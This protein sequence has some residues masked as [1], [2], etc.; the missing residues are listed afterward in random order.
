V[1]VF[2][3]L[4][5]HLDRKTTIFGSNSKAVLTHSKTIS[6]ETSILSTKL[7]DFLKSSSQHTLK[8]RTEAT[9]FQA[10][11]LDTL[12][13]HSERINAQLQRVQEVLEV[14]QGKETVSTEALGVVCTVMKET[15]ESIKNGFG[16]WADGLKKT[17][18]AMC[19]EVEASEA[20]GFITVEKAL[21][22]MGCLIETIVREA[23]EVINV[24][25]ASVLQAKSLANTAANS[26]MV[27]LRQQ[28]EMLTRLLEC[29]RIKADRTKDELIQRITGLLGDYTRDRDKGLREAVGSIQQSNEEAEE[30]MRVFD[31]KYEGVVDEMTQ[32]AVM[33][34]GV[35]ERRSGE[36]KR[37]RDGAIKTMSVARQ[38]FGEELTKMQ[39]TVSGSIQTHSNQVQ[40]QTQAMNVTCVDGEWT[41][42][43]KSIGTDSG[44]PTAFDRH[45]GAKRARV[46]ATN[47]LMSDV[48]SEY[49]YLQRGISSTSRNIDAAVGR[50]VSE[51]SRLISLNVSFIF[52]HTLS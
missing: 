33:A 1:L 5:N 26:E 7:E 42:S 6:S 31:E 38:R 40:K 30:E 45:T 46:E 28:N 25:R 21:K 8:L 52:L 4:I 23:Q 20:T 14:I 18:D 41:L 15:H 12:A 29:E 44:S 11:E 3:T 37:T 32:R 39:D 24:E 19:G 35:L 36:G 47:A 22:A 51:V 13:T 16:A 34:G 17:C 48:L 10:K 27:R 43:T 9:Q 49:R 2:P 50:V